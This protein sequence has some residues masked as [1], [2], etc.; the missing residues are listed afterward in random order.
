MIIDN[1]ADLLDDE[2]AVEASRTYDR[3]IEQ[4]FEL[5]HRLLAEGKPDEAEKVA[6]GA[7]LLR[8][9][10]VSEVVV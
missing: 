7:A 8:R 2:P 6:K 9:F 5:A 4:H 1:A 3:A 10:A